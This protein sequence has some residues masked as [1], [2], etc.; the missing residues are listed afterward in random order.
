MTGQHQRPFDGFRHHFCRAAGLEFLQVAII[1]RAH[2]HRNLG[3][4]GTGVRQ[5]LHGASNVNVG[6]DH[7]TGPRQTGCDQRLQPRRIAK[8]N[9]ITGR[10]RLAHTIRVEIEGHVG[11]ALLVQDAGQVLPTTSIATDDHMF[12]RIDGLAGNRRHLQGLLQPLTG[13]Q[14]HHDSVAVH[15]DERRRQ[16]GQHHC[17]QNRIEELRGNQCVF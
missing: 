17:R 14:L 16:H 10:S 4:M 13:N 1:L 15:D 9:R 2:D 7:R 5:H 11:N 12:V 6:H 8:H 3:R